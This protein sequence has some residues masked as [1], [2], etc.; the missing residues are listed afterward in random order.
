MKSEKFLNM[1]YHSYE[2]SA[3]KAYFYSYLLD[4]NVKQNS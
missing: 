2:D 3:L 4:N 1:S